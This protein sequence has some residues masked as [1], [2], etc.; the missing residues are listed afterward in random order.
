[1][2]DNFAKAFRILRAAYGFRQGVVA[3]K[4]GITQTRLSFIEKGRAAPSVQ[5]I[6]KASK[7]FGVSMP[8]LT[9]LANIPES[10]AKLSKNHAD[11]MAR[12]SVELLSLMVNAEEGTDPKPSGEPSKEDI[13]NAALMTVVLLQVLAELPTESPLQSLGAL[14]AK[15]L[16]NTAKITVALLQVLAEDDAKPTQ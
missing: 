14:S 2:T 15:E 13:R 1:M 8:L 4:L 12:M 10:W 11:K 3:A 9:L 6:N 7:V 16:K 5:E